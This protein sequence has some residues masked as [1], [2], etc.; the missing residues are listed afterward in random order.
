MLGR[1]EYPNEDLRTPENLQ[2]FLNAPFTPGQTTP[3]MQ[4]FNFAL[5]KGKLNRY[6]TLELAR[7]GTIPSFQLLL[8]ITS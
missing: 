5:T 8:S 3:A 6:E 4:Y 7:A 2:K 1:T